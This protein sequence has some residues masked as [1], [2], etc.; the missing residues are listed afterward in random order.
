M[1]K[2]KREKQGPPKSTHKTKDPNSALNAY[3]VVNG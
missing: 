2:R 3:P 1:A